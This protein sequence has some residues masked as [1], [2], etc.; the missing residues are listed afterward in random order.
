MVGRQK[1]FHF[2]FL[3]F[4]FFCGLCPEAEKREKSKCG[5]KLKHFLWCSLHESNVIYDVL[6]KTQQVLSPA[7]AGKGCV[8]IRRSV[9]FCVFVPKK[10]WIVHQQVCHHQ[11]DSEDD[12]FTVTESSVAPLTCAHRLLQ[13]CQSKSFSD[14]PK[15][16][17]F[18]TAC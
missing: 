16:T 7:P 18:R 12:L 3:L 11:T 15:I 8:W 14:S 13:P 9:S 1:K 17:E 2:V 6:A 4:F 10:T 5:C